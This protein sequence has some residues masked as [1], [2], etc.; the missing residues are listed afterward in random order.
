MQERKE[1]LKTKSKTPAD[2]TYS[3]QIGAFQDWGN[4]ELLV[5]KAEKAGFKPFIKTN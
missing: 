4:A 2:A 1:R 3:V 5:K